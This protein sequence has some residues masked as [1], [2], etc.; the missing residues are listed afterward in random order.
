[1]KSIRVRF[2]LARG[3][4]YMKWKVEYPN[5]TVEYH[6]VKEVQLVMR[7]CKLKNYKNVAEKI[8]KGA[9][10]EVCAWVLCDDLL[11]KQG[12]FLKDEG[13][14]RVK[15]NPREIPHWVYKDGMADGESFQTLIS[16]DFG[17]Y[18]MIK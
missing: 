8:Y 9:N 12:D 15:Y 16:V 3:K 13:L 4:N 10:K 11:I 14:D 1:M 5:K 7:N 6:D 2:N 18:C 17:L